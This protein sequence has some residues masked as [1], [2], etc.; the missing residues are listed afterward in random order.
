VLAELESVESPVPLD[1]ILDSWNQGDAQTRRE[2][3]QTLFD[4]LDVCDGEIVSTSLARIN[5]TKWPPYSARSSTARPGPGMRSRLSLLTVDS[6][7]SR[8]EAQR[9]A[10]RGQQALLPGLFRHASVRGWPGSRCAG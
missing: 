8:S 5:R 9:Q 4:E 7:P 10:Q 2:L 1:G 6:T 3:W